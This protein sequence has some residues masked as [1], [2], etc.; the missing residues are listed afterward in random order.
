VSSLH[1]K[2]CS[3]CPS[4]KKLHTLLYLIKHRAE[5]AE[6]GGVMAGGLS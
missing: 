4:L 2:T 1:N 5:G 3:A 6:P